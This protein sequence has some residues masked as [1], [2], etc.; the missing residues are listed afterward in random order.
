MVL[1][2]MKVIK[3]V[4]DKLPE[5]CNGDY[6]CQFAHYRNQTNHIECVICQKN[7]LY[8]YY[9]DTKPEWCPLEK[10]A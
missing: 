1:H 3:I 9:E 8:Y 7:I 2:K 6:K 10:E 5:M 4:V